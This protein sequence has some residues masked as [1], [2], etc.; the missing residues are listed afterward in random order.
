MPSAIT[1][2]ANKDQNEN[3]SAPNTWGGVHFAR[4]EQYPGVNNSRIEHLPKC[5][6]QSHSRSELCWPPWLLPKAFTGLFSVVCN[7][8]LDLEREGL[9]YKTL[10]PDHL[11]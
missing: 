9:K 3:N 1:K 8:G 2:G 10:V 11:L 7:P 5:W 6:G 4:S